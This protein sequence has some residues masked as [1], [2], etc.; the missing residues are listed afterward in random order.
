MKK[1]IKI[2]ETAFVTSTFRASDT[3]VSKDV[4]AQLWSSA[5]ANEK[6]DHYARVVST[7]EP[8]AH[9]LRN[10]FFY[11]T[12]NSLQKDGAIEV[13][14]N[15]GA[16]FSMYPFLLDEKLIHIEIDKPDI[17]EYKKGEIAQW[18]RNGKLPSRTIHYVSTDFNQDQE[19]RLLGEIAKIKGGKNCFILIEGVLF[20]ISKNDTER[21]FRLFNKIQVAGDY[22]GSVSFEKKLEQTT[23]FQKMVKFI[24]RNLATNAQFQYQTIEDD[25]YTNLP[26]YRRVDHQDHLH[27]GEKYDLP[28]AFDPDMLLNEHMY[29]LQKNNKFPETD[30]PR[31]KP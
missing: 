7:Y 8:I 21:L 31:V 9:C 29:I 23:V 6:A 25:F 12:I 4:F 24:E 5:Q 15:F 26:D 3:A 19:V 2:H 17:I 20:F 11:D 30:Y 27:L 14:I 13:L 1:T 16:G 28:Y 22:I 10:R 18:V